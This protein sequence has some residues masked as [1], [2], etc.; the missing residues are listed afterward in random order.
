MAFTD[1]KTFLS[2]WF[3]RLA[4]SGWSGSLFLDTLADDVVRTAIGSS[5]VSGTYPGKQEYTDKVYKPLD[6]HLAT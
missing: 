4:K 6:E 3:E 1:T 5:P 2:E